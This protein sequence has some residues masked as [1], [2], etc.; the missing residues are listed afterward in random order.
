MYIYT[1]HICFAI[2]DGIPSSIQDELEDNHCDYSY[3][4]Y[5]D[6]CG[7]LS[8]IKPKDNRKRAAT[9]IKNIVSARVAFHSDI[10]KSVRVPRKKKART[11][12]L[13]N[14]P[15]TKVP[16]HLGIQRHCVLC[17][18]AGMTEKKYMLHSDEDYFDKHSDQKS[19][20]D[21]L[22]GPMVSITEAV[23]QWEKSE[24]K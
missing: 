24:N 5:E 12:V 22:G 18:K 10:N 13:R 6:W 21:G 23:K 8:T 4:A 20:R 16:K 2:K 1:Y 9:Q 7:L 3:F 19:I 14:N 17:K 11:G 15:N